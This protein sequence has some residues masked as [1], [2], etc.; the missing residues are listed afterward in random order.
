LPS[1]PE[2]IRFSVLPVQQSYRL[3]RHIPNFLIVYAYLQSPNI[4]KWS[5]GIW[6]AQKPANWIFEIAH[7]M[8]LG[9][10]PLGEEAP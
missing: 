7:E 8:S 1:A 10:S 3:P 6:R 2:K 5:K 4:P 9:S